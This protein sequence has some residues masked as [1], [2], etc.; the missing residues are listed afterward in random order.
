MLQHSSDLAEY[1]DTWESCGS[2]MIA[3]WEILKKIL[4][5]ALE[6]S[7]T[8]EHVRPRDLIADS[9]AMSILTAKGQG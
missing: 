8:S 2:N 3:D 6:Q 9:A 1:A 4:W 5:D 7:S